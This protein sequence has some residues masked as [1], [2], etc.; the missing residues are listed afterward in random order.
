MMSPPNSE[1]AVMIQGLSKV[2]L[3]WGRSAAQSL[4]TKA[5]GMGKNV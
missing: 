2:W 3:R 5:K 4:S 1:G